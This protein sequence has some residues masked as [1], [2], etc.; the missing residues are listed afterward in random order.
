MRLLSIGEVLHLHRLVV[1]SSVTLGAGSCT[2]VSRALDR[3]REGPLDPAPSSLAREALDDLKFAEC[4]PKA[5]AAA[6][7][8]T[9]LADAE[10]V[11]QAA[12]FAVT[13]VIR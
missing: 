2:R 11:R 10:G 9:R 12:G 5:L 3:L 13:V 8:R 7:L 4:V 1:A 6:M